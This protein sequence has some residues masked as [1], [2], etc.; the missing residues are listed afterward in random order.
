MG[1]AL[2]SKYSERSETDIEVFDSNFLQFQP[3][4]RMTARSYLEFIDEISVSILGC[5]INDEGSI[6]ILDC[7]EL[8]LVGVSRVMTVI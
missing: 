8:F 7:R 6:A 5:M 2:T 4:G 1:P 3:I